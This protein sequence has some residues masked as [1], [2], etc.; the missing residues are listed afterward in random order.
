MT[1]SGVFGRRPLAVPAF[2]AVAAALVLT[3]CGGAG[4]STEKEAK[5]SG[6]ELEPGERSSQSE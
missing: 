3:G 2:A 5:L 6:S 4:R 1:P